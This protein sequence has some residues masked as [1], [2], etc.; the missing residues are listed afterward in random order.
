MQLAPKPARKEVD[1]SPRRIES[2]SAVVV[3][4][5]LIAFIGLFY[6]S[7]WLDLPRSSL[8]Q[9]LDRPK[10]WRKAPRPGKLGSQG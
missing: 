3:I 4:G 5:C 6:Y 9:S 2:R 10:D 7:L 1:I 8:P